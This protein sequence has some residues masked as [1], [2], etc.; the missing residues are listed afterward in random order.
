MVMIT[1]N[2]ATLPDV[3]KASEDLHAFAKANEGRL[4]KLF[5]TC[6]DPQTDLK[7]LVKSTV[8]SWQEL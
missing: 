6:I 1:A 4:Y 3:Q 8:R 2:P 5:K 7:G